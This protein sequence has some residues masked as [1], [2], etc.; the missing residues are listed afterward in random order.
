ML[1]YILSKSL[2]LL[3][4]EGRKQR[5]WECGKM[6]CARLLGVGGPGGVLNLEEPTEGGG[7]R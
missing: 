3:K 4:L 7:K 2:N 5:L 6:G 1:G